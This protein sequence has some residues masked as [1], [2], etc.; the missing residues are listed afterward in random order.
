MVSRTAL[1]QF[2]RT[3][4]GRDCGGA[5]S[6]VDK[7]CPE[8]HGQGRVMV[9]QQLEVDVPPG[10]ATGQSI[11]LTGRGSAGEP[12]G[13]APWGAGSPSFRRRRPAPTSPAA[14]PS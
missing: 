2:V 12:G 11:R 13:A 3:G 10:I 14:G 4:P 9:D 1:G 8:C 7:P 5:G 6:T